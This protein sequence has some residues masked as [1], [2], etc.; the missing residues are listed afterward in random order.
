MNKIEEML[1]VGNKKAKQMRDVR[2]ALWAY[3]N[4]DELIPKDLDLSVIKPCFE[5][6]DEDDKAVLDKVGAD[7]DF[8]QFHLLN[9]Y[10]N[11]M[12]CN[13][14]CMCGSQC[15]DFSD[16]TC[17]DDLADT[18]KKINSVIDSLI[19][20]FQ[21]EIC[22]FYD[23]KN[24]L[25]EKLFKA[26]YFELVGYHVSEDTGND[27]LCFNG[28]NY[29]FHLPA[30]KSSLDIKLDVD[31]PFLGEIGLIPSYETDS[32]YSKYSLKELTAMLEEML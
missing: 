32:E 20:D 30:D 25:I 5:R 7:F 16:C 28:E 27:L 22:C 6:L 3:I 21:L 10:P 8:C 17:D 26:N 13:N 12:L 14:G 29:S 4:E 19:S 18:V 24:K 11:I 15:D 1:H 31:T 23:V 9:E 2:Q